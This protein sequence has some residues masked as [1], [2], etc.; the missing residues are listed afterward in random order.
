MKRRRYHQVHDGVWFRPTMKGHREQCCG[1]GLVHLVDYQIVRVGK[2]KEGIMY[3]A[4]VDEKETKAVRRRRR[5][6]V[7]KLD[8]G[9]GE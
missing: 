5:I 7:S 3:R 8:G 2:N 4:T 9:A 1:C 6:S